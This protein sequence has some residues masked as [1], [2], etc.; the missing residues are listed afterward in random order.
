M[1]KTTA[2]FFA[3]ILSVSAFAQ[4]NTAVDIANY[5]YQ[6]GFQEGYSK[7]YETGYKRGYLDALNDAK[8]LLKALNL[9]I[10]AVKASCSLLQE[11]YGQ[12]PAIV[13]VKDKNGNLYLKPFLSDLEPVENFQELAQRG[14]PVI[15]VA[16]ALKVKKAQA[17]LVNIPPL[18]EEQT[19]YVAQPP[20]GN[21]IVKLPKSLEPALKQQNISY[22]S[23]KDQNYLIAV[24]P[25][26]QIFE[27][28]CKTYNCNAKKP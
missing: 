21:Y 26:K 27:D 28:F 13:I 4:S 5:M 16:L 9:E 20:V 2:F 15:D 25:S 23:I 12:V 24:F 10:K 18:S 3:T 19:D 17:D 1:Q 14:I 11:K 7:G 22:I 6:K 8:I